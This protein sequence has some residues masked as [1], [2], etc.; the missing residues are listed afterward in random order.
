LISGKDDTYGEKLDG[1][2]L[3]WLILIAEVKKLRTV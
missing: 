1:D 3:D 2:L